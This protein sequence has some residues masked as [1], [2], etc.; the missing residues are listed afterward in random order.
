MG[1]N[2][3][4]KIL[5]HRAPSPIGD[6]ATEIDGLQPQVVFKTAHL[7][8]P[9]TIRYVKESFYMQSEFTL[10]T[11]KFYLILKQYLHAARAAS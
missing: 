1:P 5:N 7:H 6:D 2:P 11:K 3:K 10:I 4:F 8:R 9:I